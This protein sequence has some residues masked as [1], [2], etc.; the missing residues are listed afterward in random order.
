M[1]TYPKNPRES[2]EKKKGRKEGERKLQNI[3]S[4]VTK[5]IS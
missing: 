5:F 4:V 1:I 3:Q 2:D